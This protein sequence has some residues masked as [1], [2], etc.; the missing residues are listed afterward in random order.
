MKKHI[1]FI[2]VYGYRLLRIGRRDGNLWAFEAMYL[3]SRHGV[4]YRFSAGL[5]FGQ[6]AWVH[7]HIRISQYSLGL[8]IMPNSYRNR[9]A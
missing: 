1:A 5:V 9:A 8:R 3:R 6:E 2:N 7:A 4:R